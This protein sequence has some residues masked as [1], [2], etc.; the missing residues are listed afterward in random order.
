MARRSPKQSKT[1]KQ[2]EGQVSLWDI[3]ITKSDKLFTK[4]KEDITEI[5]NP[6]TNLSEED[7]KCDNEK[8]EKELIVTDKQQRFLEKNKVMENES[9][10]RI[11]LLCSGSLLV[12]F[13]FGENYKTICINKDGVI[14][15]SY[16]KRIAII[17]M[18]KIV[19]FK[20]DVIINDIQAK[21]VEPFKQAGLKIVKREGDEN[22]MAIAKDK[23]ISIN[24]QGWVL[25]YRNIQA[26]YDAS[27]IVEIKTEHTDGEIKVGDTVEVDFGGNI[28]KGVATRIYNQGDT[29]N[30]IFNN[31][32][33]A[34]HI[35][36]IKKVKGAG[37]SSPI[38]AIMH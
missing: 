34:F 9:L 22:I 2:I 28:Y 10:S 36:K 35:S 38:V 24:K 37:Y 16:D 26:I 11:T 7:L 17:P 3:E 5:I 21:R 13:I 8:S 25:E 4:T 20:N 23:V 30:C 15:L 27:E 32:H 18:D 1:T 29:I 33:S 31:K 6:I 14:E 19:Y 12:E